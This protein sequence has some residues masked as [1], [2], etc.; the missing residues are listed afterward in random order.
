[1]SRSVCRA[2]SSAVPS[3]DD[4]G[5]FLAFPVNVNSC[6]KGILENRDDVAVADRH[7]VEAGHATF[8][9]G[10]REVKLIGFHREQ[11]LAR[12][13][14]LAEAGEDESDHLLES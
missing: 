9:G 12:A 5:A 4:G 8:V 1:M 11:N 14:E 13:A 10:P 2:R 3:F 7:P 6:I